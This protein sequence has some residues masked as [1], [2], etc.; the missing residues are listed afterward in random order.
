MLARNAAAL[1][2]GLGG[3]LVASTAMAQCAPGGCRAWTP[4]SAAYAVAPQGGYAPDR[5]GPGPGEGAAPGYGAANRYGEGYGY[6]AAY[7]Q[8]YGM[9][10]CDV[11]ATPQAY[12]APPVEAPQIEVSGIGAGFYSSDSAGGVISGEDFGGGGGGGGSSGLGAFE[13]GFGDSSAFAS[14]NTAAFASATSQAYVNASI[15][16]HANAMANAYADA[17]AK[18]SAS[19]QASS[20]S[21]SS[22]Q[23]NSWNNQVESG[24]QAVLPGR[25]LGEPGLEVRGRFV[26]RR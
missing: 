17:Q 26:G 8:S 6:V 18:A 22:S 12:P 5:Y 25:L 15:Q 13:Q 11:C 21:S 9:G 16:A 2:A 7:G 20:S 19:A 4:A 10:R 3:L 23:S 24:R 14:A 1:A